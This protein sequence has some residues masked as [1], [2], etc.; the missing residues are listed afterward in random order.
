MKVVD[1]SLENDMQGKI[2]KINKDFDV[3]QERGTEGETEGLL[4]KKRAVNT[5]YLIVFDSIR[6]PFCLN[7]PLSIEVSFCLDNQR[8]LQIRK[9]WKADGDGNEI[10]FVWCRETLF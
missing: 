9:S 1:L 7:I 2:H 3:K 5:S 4:C 8:L 6:S 10:R